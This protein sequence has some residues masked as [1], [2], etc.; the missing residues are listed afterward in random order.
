MY[1]FANTPYHHNI[2]AGLYAAPRS[3]QGLL[4]DLKKEHKLLVPDI[5]KND[6]YAKLGKDMADYGVCCDLFLAGSEYAD[7]ISIGECD[8][9][10]FCFPPHDDQAS[11]TMFLFLNS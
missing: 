9:G 1:V 4:G 6:F 2:G 10:N 3:S 5:S 7:I 11:L 8:S